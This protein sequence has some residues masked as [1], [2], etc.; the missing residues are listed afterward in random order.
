MPYSTEDI[1]HAA[2]LGFNDFNSLPPDLQKAT[3]D[4]LY[5]NGGEGFNANPQHL[6]D[7]QGTFQEHRGSEY[8][9]RMRALGKQQASPFVT[10]N[11]EAL[12]ASR[13]QLADSYAKQKQAVGM[14]RA[15]AEGNGPS[16]ALAQ[17]TAQ[18]DAGV[19]SM[20]GATGGGLRAG[21][22]GG[23]LQN[24]AAQ[25]GQAY[26]QEIGQAQSAWGQGGQALRGG[27]LQD[28]Q[29][30]LSAAYGASKLNLSQQQQDMA[31]RLAYEKMALG[32]YQMDVAGQNALADNALGIEERETARANA[33][34]AGM[35]NA[36]GS[37]LSAAYNAY[38][39]G[40]AKDR[41][42]KGGGKSWGEWEG[43]DY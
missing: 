17:G 27:S 19:R 20:S 18:Q 28:Q 43:P 33:Y 39:S 40:G 30:G 15:A 26:G 3:N 36:A 9:D 7:I 6:K 11:H 29:Q 14:Q 5:Y 25:T 4:Y 16:V 22:M 12:D 23:G 41:S 21:L 31:R 8:A 2:T 34:T 38:G 24:V 1:Q 42:G 13:K 10:V 35:T 32:G 37:G